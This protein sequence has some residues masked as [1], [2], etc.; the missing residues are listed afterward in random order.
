M[1]LA[2]Y[3]ALALKRRYLPDRGPLWIWVVPVALF[4][5]GATVVGLA[6]YR[7]PLYPFLP[8]LGAIGVVAWLERRVS[9]PPP[10]AG[11]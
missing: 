10:R 5:A 2:A 9:R 6:R 7:A 8:L 4:V 3:G 1:L 11:S